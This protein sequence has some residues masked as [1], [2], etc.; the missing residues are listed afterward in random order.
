MGRDFPR[1]TVTFRVTTAA[2]KAEESELPSNG[3]IRVWIVTAEVSCLDS[4]G[5]VAAERRHDLSDSVDSL[6]DPLGDGRTRPFGLGRTASI[7]AA[8]SDGNGQLLGY[9]VHLAA[10]PG[11][12]VGIVKPF[13]L[14]QIVPQLNNPALVF[15]LGL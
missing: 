15:C 1:H 14:L 11:S 2:G 9:R 13:R 12:T 5:Q 7:P 10:G 8:E 3:T 6:F 4:R